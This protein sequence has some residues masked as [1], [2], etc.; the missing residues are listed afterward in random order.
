MTYR[1]ITLQK[2]Y[3]S[4]SSDADVLLDFYVPLLEK[5]VSYDRLSGFFSSGALAVAARGIAGLIHNGG[6][7]RIVASPNFTRRDLEALQNAGD[8]GLLAAATA[9]AE[10][11]LN[12]DELA[13]SIARDHVRAMAWMLAEGR[14]EIK[15]VVPS[16][17]ADY[18]DGLFH[19]KVG[20][21]R[22]G[23]GN[24]V[25][26][27]GSINETAAG[28]TDNIEEFKVFR[29]W[30]ASER[31]YLNRDEELFRRY[32]NGGTQ[33]ARVVAL[34][35][36]ARKKLM[37]Y[38]P[39][40]VEEL[41]LD[42]SKLRK[43]RPSGPKFQLRSYQ[44][45][46]VDAW[47][48]HNCRGIFEMATGTGKTKTAI[49]CIARLAEQPG[50]QL[51][52]ITAPY[53]HIAVQWAAELE[54]KRLVTTFGAGNWRA[55]LNN[56]ASDAKLG[57]A[58]EAYVVAVQNTA[59]M[60]DFLETVEGLAKTYDRV[61]YIGDECHGL[62]APEMRKALGEFYTHRLGLSATPTRW[63]DDDGTAVLHDFFGETVFVFG[64][65]EALNWVD[66]VTGLTPLCP[67]KY[68]PRF[69][70]LDGEELEEYQELTNKLVTL[71][72]AE[73]GSEAH[74]IY[75]RLLFKRADIVKK[76]SAKIGE[77]GRILDELG[78]VDHCLVY[79]HSSEQMLEAQEQLWKRGI[80]YSRFTGAEGTTPSDEFGGLSER[81]HILGS[82]DRGDV[83]AL[84]AMKCLDEGV[85]VPSAR[86][87]IILASSGNPREFVQRRGRLLRRAPGKDFA[88]IY[89]LVVT[90]NIDWLADERVRDIERKLLAKELQRVD[91]FAENAS[92]G[93][94]ARTEVLRLLAKLL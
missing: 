74:D 12:L 18:G 7:M 50:K 77:L 58:R 39:T 76:A 57:R 78:Q 90:P 5:S 68:W 67:Y 15:L 92:N 55:E 81:E 56:L 20:I 86:L 13:D 79:C 93:L 65:H 83:D 43:R 9:A 32:W 11:A 27:G 82:L 52:V 51:T 19:Q 8:E 6:S 91:E 30:E 38:A 54:G 35:D 59:S 60:H 47:F 63:F 14:L 10:S 61:A 44:A 24:I 48:D 28:W 62:G 25:S 17:T 69:V 89:D 84:V 70:S 42:L 37:S 1:D 33:R 16:T 36:A 26:F 71:M 46:A 21:L 22:D 29:S 87:G 45:E 49:A 73:Q 53:Q 94:E 2:A 80:R 88:L 40:D 66:P 3:D 34:P 64:I 23:V 41:D 4:G 85:D 75:E 31:E 72:S